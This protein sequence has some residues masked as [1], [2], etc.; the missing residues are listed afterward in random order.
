MKLSCAIVT[1]LQSASALVCST[2]EE[3]SYADC[4]ANKQ[5][6]TCPLGPDETPYKNWSCQLVEGQGLGNRVNLVIAGCKQHEAAY[7]DWD[8]NDN[9]NSF[10]QCEPENKRKISKCRQLC[11]SDNCVDS[12]LSASGMS[13]AAWLTQPATPPAGR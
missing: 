12:W 1:L 8:N 10:P 9:P 7:A 6:V 3:K 13:K 11:T 4:I 5:S 2:C